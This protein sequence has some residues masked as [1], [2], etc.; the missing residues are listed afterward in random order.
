MVSDTLTLPSRGG[1]RMEWKGVGGPFCLLGTKV[2]GAVSK[3][4]KLCRG[5]QTCLRV[6]NKKLCL[7]NTKKKALELK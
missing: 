2:I 6:E 1:G 5:L 7:L 3:D 4:H